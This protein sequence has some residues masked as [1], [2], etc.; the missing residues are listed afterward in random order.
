MFCIYLCH[1]CVKK[2]TYA[3]EQARVSLS[4][5]PGIT[6]WLHNFTSCA[7]AVTSHVFSTLT[8]DVLFM[9]TVF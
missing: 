4:L 7:L 6:T 2:V 8:H 9:M 5:Q 1:H 3:K